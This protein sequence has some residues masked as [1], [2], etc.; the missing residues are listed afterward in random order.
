MPKFTFISPEKKEF[1]VEAPIGE[2]L[3]EIA[4]KNNVDGIDADCGGACA[5]ATCH[6]IFNHADLSKVG[7]ADEDESALL[8][9]L[10]GR[11][12]GSRLSCQVIMKEDLDGLT[13]EIPYP[14]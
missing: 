13:V 4:V 11:K 9:F 8:D 3:M 2:T 5:C 12:M 6:I 7:Y 14:D 1:N 10:N